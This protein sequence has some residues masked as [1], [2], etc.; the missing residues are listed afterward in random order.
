MKIILPNPPVHPLWKRGAGG[1][2]KGGWGDFQIK[3]ICFLSV[4]IF[5]IILISGTCSA[6]STSLTNPDDIRYQPLTFAPPEAERVELKNGIILYILEDHEIPL[7]NI[8]AVIRTG[9]IYDPQGKEGLAE[10]TGAVMRTGGTK[11]RTGDEIDEEIEYFAGSITV[12]IGME[13]G[14]ATLSVLKKDLED[15]LDIFSDII[16]NPSHHYFF[17]GSVVVM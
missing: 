14:S 12:S 6:E 17:Q 16:M 2:F 10:I 3:K 13:A 15:G 8:S 9:S 4:L 5:F 11:K 7:I 1:I